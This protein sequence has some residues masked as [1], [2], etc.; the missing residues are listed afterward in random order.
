MNTK[1]APAL[2]FLIAALLPWAL[3]ACSR[4]SDRPAKGG[5]PA[6][7]AAASEVGSPAPDFVL[8]DVDAN[9]TRLSDRKGKKGVLLVFWAT[10]CPA[11]VAKIPTLN[12]IHPAYE[13]KGLEVISVSIQQR[14]ALVKRFI[15]QKRI[16]YRVLLDTDGNVAQ[17]YEVQGIP[18]ILGIDASGV[19]RYRDH[20]LPEGA[21][22]DKLVAELTKG[23]AAES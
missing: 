20:V 11:C 7:P 5:E 6:A 14:A 15:K 4:E 12:K 23:V 9:E 17:T 10:W 16:V 3:G 13:A 8:K 18:L 2:V 21:Q 22:W 19:I 1:K